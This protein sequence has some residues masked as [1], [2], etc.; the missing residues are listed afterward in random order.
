MLPFHIPKPQAPNLER[1][2]TSRGRRDRGDGGYDDRDDFK[3]TRRDQGQGGGGGYDQMPPPPLTQGGG[4]NGGGPG[5][6][7]GGY[8]VSKPKP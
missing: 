7:G 4:G 1:C 6:G 3:R 8:Q 2:N 5:A